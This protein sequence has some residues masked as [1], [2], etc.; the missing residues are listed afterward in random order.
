MKKIAIVEDEIFLREELALILKKAGYEILKIEN[1]DNVATGILSSSVDLVLLDLNLPN[2]S[3][4]QICRDLKNSSSIPV[5]VLTSRDKLQDEINAL[6]L[7]ADEFLTKPCKS[8]RLIARISNVLKRFEG[9]N[10]LLEG[11]DF[12]LDRNTYTLYING[13]SVIIPQNQG[14]LLEA[15][16]LSKSGFVSKDELS[17]MLWRTTEFID[18]NALQVNITR[19]KKT[20]A[21]LKMGYQIISIRGKGYEFKPN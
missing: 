10:N 16:L 15:F 21:E 5:L 6:S 14:K 1:F 8:E 17:L 2:Q 12:L 18:E 9:R 3:G 11:K 20:I 7:G 4:F 13:T 19:L